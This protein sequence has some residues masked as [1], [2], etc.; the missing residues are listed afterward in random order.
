MSYNPFEN[1]D[2][3]FGSHIRRKKKYAWVESSFDVENPEYQELSTS[4][5][6]LYVG[7]IISRRTFWWFVSIF[8]IGLLLIIGRV[9][10]LQIFQGKSFLALA[11]KNRVRILPIIAERGIISDRFGKELVE[12]VPNFYV[13]IVPQGL[14]SASREPQKRAEIIHRVAELA[15]ISPEEVEKI[16]SKLD[17]QSPHRASAYQ[18]LVIKENLDYTAALK[19]YL[20]NSDLP[21]IV[22]GNGYKRH[23][24]NYPQENT[25][26]TTASSTLSLSPI[27]GYLNKITDAEW[28]EV[29]NDNYLLNDNIGKIGVEKTY[30]KELRGI[31]GKKRI[32]VDARDH[33]QNIIEVEPAIPGKNIQLT[34]DLEAQQKLE[35]LI[36]EELIKAK[37]D[38]AAAIAMNPQTGE[39]IA[40]V[41]YPSYDNNDFSGGISQE[42]YDIYIKNPNNPLFNRAISGSFPPG[43]TL[44]PVIAAAALQ[45]G[46]VNKNTSFNSTG[47]IRVGPSFFPDWKA[48]GH[49]Q[50]NVTKAIA[51]SVNTF[52]YYIGGGYDQFAGLGIDAMHRYMEKFNLSKKTGIDLP[53]ENEGFIPTK[54]WKQETWGEPWYLGDTYNTS[55]GQGYILVTPLQ[56]AVWTSA[57]AN[58]GKIVVPHIVS[59]ITD[60]ATKVTTSVA[61]K[62]ISENMVNPE[63]ISIVRQGMRECVTYGSCRQLSALPFTSGGK[64][65]TAQWKNNK[66]NHAWFSGFAPYENPKIVVVVLV[67][68]GGEGSKTAV[69]IAY[70][71]LEWWGKKYLTH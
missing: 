51:W 28:R 9:F 4:H 45:E 46:I 22:V 62:F 16:E 56:V 26:T 23:Y 33:E 64:T 8:G 66:E 70:K 5:T 20:Q 2:S 3:T 52:F 49:G 48:G 7:T 58:S 21:G 67:E 32:E 54:K 37:K 10:Y 6:K 35:T 30:E 19:I 27:L 18:S 12:N 36:R 71:F 29:K 24:F 59:E 15:N 43:S 69:P 17:P 41:N 42:K 40:L 44:K 1:L 11:E 68:E 25:G 39:V 57:F 13:S 14:P 61:P 47:G 60:P 65:G 50:T 53:G 31:Y 63:A 38:R 55:I 34:I